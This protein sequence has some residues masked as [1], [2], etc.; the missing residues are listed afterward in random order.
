M[1]GENAVLVTLGNEVSDRTNDLALS[2]CA[3]LE[4]LDL[5]GI[6][7]AQPAYSSFCVHFNSSLIR[8]S[9][10]AGVT[11]ELLGELTAEISQGL[12]GET[13][14]GGTREGIENPPSRM[15]AETCRNASKKHGRLVEIPVVYGGEDGPDLQWASEVLRMSQEEIVGLHSGRDYRVYM[16]GFTP[17][18]PYLGGMDESISLP[19]LPEPRKVV[20]AGSVGIAGTQTGIYPW[21]SPGG[22]RILGRTP[23]RLFEPLEDDPSLIH[24][25]DTV[26]FAPVRR[27]DSRPTG[28]SASETSAW[29][30]VKTAWEPE[31]PGYRRGATCASETTGRWRKVGCEEVGG[32]F[33]SIPGFRVETPGFLSL[34]VDEG[35]PWHR[36]LGVPVSGAADLASYRL[37][38]A[39]CGNPHGTPALEM[40]YLGGKLIAETSLTVAIA[41][42]PA[43]I[44]VNGSLV[45]PSGPILVPE[46]ALLEIGPMMTG[47]RA[48]LAVSGGFHVKKILG[49][50][51]TYLRG[52]FGGF[53]GRALKAGDILRVGPSPEHQEIIA[54]GQ[55]YPY[56]KPLSPL[57]GDVFSGTGEI[58][59]RVTPGP[60]AQGQIAPALVQRKGPLDALCASIYTVRPESDRMGLRFDGPALPFGG[61][62]LSSPVVPGTIQVPSDGHPLLLLADAQTTGGYKRVAVLSSECLGIAGQLRPGDRVRFVL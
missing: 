52:R 49:S 43:P 58:V 20:P 56:L 14:K 11:R 17:G 50:S 2:T 41:G 60:E 32:A 31:I 4:M 59:L 8:A 36:K 37:A 40:T 18:F 5:P 21:D 42:A 6:V 12:T 47:C 55:A 54:K 57:Y 61:D 46:G 44:S 33:Q 24:P 23:L 7:E 38:N 3:A 28:A 29:A 51:S 62:I 27:D 26:R 13:L 1:L 34:I 10:I 22:W 45:Q 39:Y 15:S 9:Y 16:L 25:G 35:R 30:S 53:F 48:Y 19:R